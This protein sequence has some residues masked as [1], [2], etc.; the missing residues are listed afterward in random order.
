MKFLFSCLILSAIGIAVA[1][2]VCAKFQWNLNLQDFAN[3]ATTATFLS[4]GAAF[5]ALWFQ[6]KG[7]R[8]D[9]KNNKARLFL[10]EELR[11]V[12]ELER[13]IQGMR[14]RLAI[15]S[16]ALVRA[17]VLSS[18][19][20]LNKGDWRIRI[21]EARSEARVAMNQIERLVG[22]LVRFKVV[23]VITVDRLAPKSQDSS[24]LEG[25]LLK[26]FEQ[27]LQPQQEGSPP[28][29]KPFDLTDAEVQSRTQAIEAIFHFMES[30]L[31]H[32]R[33]AIYNRAR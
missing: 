19:P 30:L 12:G 6:L 7:L 33:D 8:Q 15:F 4:T 11:D 32:A 9:A 28:M 24:V 25:A 31:E 5:F 16:D 2:L 1:A 10:E 27:V 20:N 17:I 26:S 14:T 23:V 22:E 18:D 29:Y 3:L 13:A 21:L